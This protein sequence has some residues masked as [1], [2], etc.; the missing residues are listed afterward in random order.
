MFLCFGIPVLGNV[1]S[2]DHHSWTSDTMF[3][4][5]VALQVS[6]HQRMGGGASY[7]SMMLGLE[8]EIPGLVLCARRS[9]PLPPQGVPGP[10]QSTQPHHSSI[11]QDEE[12]AHK[13]FCMLFQRV[14]HSFPLCSA[15]GF[16]ND[17]VNVFGWHHSEGCVFNKLIFCKPKYFCKLSH[18][19]SIYLSDT[20]YLG[21]KHMEEI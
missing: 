3:G 4:G 17:S 18:T 9:L 2:P 21:G 11:R 16:G 1:F 12:L 5:W 20:R 6:P 15:E 8:Q 10:L 14:F 13:R 7:D 19:V